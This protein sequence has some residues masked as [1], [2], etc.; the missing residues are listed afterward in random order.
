M[1][2]T[3][4][5]YIMCCCLDFPCDSKVTFTCLQSQIPVYIVMQYYYSTQITKGG[6]AEKDGRLHVGQRIL[7]VNN[8]S[9]LGASHVEA[10]HTLRHAGNDLTLLVCEGFGI[11]SLS[12]ESCDSHVVGL[13]LENG[14]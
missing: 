8:V 4:V 6:V 5:Y 9:L 13:H 11:S 7:E 12:G 10:V 1:L 3:Y 2:L 14:E